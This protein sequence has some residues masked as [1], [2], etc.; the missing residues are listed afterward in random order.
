VHLLR[1]EHPGA[2]AEALPAEAPK[3]HQYLASLVNAALVC[4]SL[5]STRS[6]VPS[7]LSRP[8]AEPPCTS[9]AGIGR[10]LEFEPGRASGYGRDYHSP[11]YRCC[12]IPS[13]SRDRRSQILF[14]NLYRRE[15]LYVDFARNSVL[16][17]NVC[18]LNKTATL[19]CRFAW[20]NPAHHPD[21]HPDRI[22]ADMALQWRWG[23]YPSGGLGLLAVI[24]IVLLLMGR[25]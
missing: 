17:L 25:I 3:S 24:V 11:K 16:T 13:R 22:T 14:A 5:I 21:S 15:Q 2:I 20:H 8:A 12:H 10:F 9:C 4:L 19:R 7:P 23:Y 1:L 6:A 18:N